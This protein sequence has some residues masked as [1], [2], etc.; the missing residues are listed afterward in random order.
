M[1][2][3]HINIDKLIP[4]INNPR[5]NEQAIDKVAASIA[6]F[7]FNVPIVIDKKN[8]II[9][10]HTRLLA[11]KKLGLDEVPCIIADKL[12]EAQVKAYRIADNRTAEFS[13]WNQDLLKIELECLNELDFDLNITGF[14]EEYFNI[15]K[16]DDDVDLDDFFYDVEPN[17]KQQQEVLQNNENE[18]ENSKFI[19][20]PHCGEK[21]EI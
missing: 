12:T 5:N 3:V 6:E 2:I 1:N 17:N 16:S 20:C 8:I 13:Q 7:G 14:N 15:L 11:A 19:T 18:E 9:T 21:V 10:G 4:Y